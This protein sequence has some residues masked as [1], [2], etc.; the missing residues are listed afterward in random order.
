[1]AKYANGSVYEGGF[2]KAL[3]HGKGTLTQPNGYRYDGDWVQGVKEGRGVSPI[4]TAL[5]T[6]AGCWPECVPVAAS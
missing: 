4:P 3:H 2:Q 5:S 1:M 6:M